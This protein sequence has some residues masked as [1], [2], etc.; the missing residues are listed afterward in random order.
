MHPGDL[1]LLSPVGHAYLFHPEN[2]SYEDFANLSPF[3]V[4]TGMVREASGDFLICDESAGAIIRLHAGSGAVSIVTLGNELAA[5]VDLDVSSDGF[6]FAVDAGLAKLVRIDPTS[7]DQVLLAQHG[8]LEGIPIS[9][10][11]G[12][13]GDLY[14]VN[15]PFGLEFV[16][17]IK[18]STG[19]QTE[20][21]V[22]GF[23]FN[24]EQ[25]TFG[26]DGSILIS[27]WTGIS[28][29]LVRV[30]PATGAQTE[31]VAEAAGSRAPGLAL[32]GQ[33]GA[34]LGDESGEL[35]RWSGAGTV[36]TVATFPFAIQAIC[37]IPGNGPVRAQGSTWG[38]VKA[39][40]R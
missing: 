30:D 19:N 36:T 21:T 14:V 11:V 9:V 29:D 34:Y 22:D 8:Y 38:G 33:G 15:E 35:L 10:Q 2:G 23:L 37:V 5:P 25:L 4:T 1:V 16:Y 28:T 32:D 31:L 18:R 12:P 6:I 24:P 39:L 7:G 3:H 13:D 17:R 40:Y 26:E 27:N 20:I